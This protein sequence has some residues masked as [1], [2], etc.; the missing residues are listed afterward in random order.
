MGSVMGVISVLD[1]RPGSSETHIPRFGNSWQSHSE[2]RATQLY[3]VDGQQ[4]I[5]QAEVRLDQR[6]HLP[7][8]SPDEAIFAMLLDRLPRLV[9]C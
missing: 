5:A 6:I 4:S 2:N 1:D 9:T 8:S 3:C 7:S